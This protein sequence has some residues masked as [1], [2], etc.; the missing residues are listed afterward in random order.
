[1]FSGRRVDPG[2]LALLRAETTPAGAGNL[3]DLGCGYGPIACTL[4]RRAPGARVWAV[5]V[6]SRALALTDANATSLGLGNVVTAEPD[7]VPG[8]VSFDEIWSN[9]PI[10]IGKEALHE[11]LERWLGRLAP[12]GRVLLVVHRHLGGDSLASWLGGR[13]FVVERRASKQ[14]YRVLAARRP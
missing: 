9:P 1:M 7:A 13:G 4:A 11:L 2:T 12:G 6:N 10:R 3:L 14:G 5:D 8:N